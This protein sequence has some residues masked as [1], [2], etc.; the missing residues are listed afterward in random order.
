[1][2]TYSLVTH[3]LQ[4]LTNILEDSSSSLVINKKD[5]VVRMMLVESFIKSIDFYFLVNKMRYVLDYLRAKELVRRGTL[6]SI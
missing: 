6:Q 3:Y 2:I 5:D 4:E 1:M